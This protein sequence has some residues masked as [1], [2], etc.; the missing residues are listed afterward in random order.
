MRSFK[1]FLIIIILTLSLASCDI[2]A[3]GSEE[4]ISTEQ[5][6]ST[7]D[8]Y[9][10]YSIN[11]DNDKFSFNGDRDALMHENDTLTII[12]GGTYELSG[13]LKQ[14]KI[15]ID[16]GD[17]CVNL[18]LSENFS[19]GDRADAAIS[20]KSSGGTTLEIKGNSYNIYFTRSN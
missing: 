9:R 3:Q 14:G 7:A 12:K 13:N 11:F 10:P 8:S 2:L 16:T 20:V 15:V 19:L 17:A 4:S 5:S 18:V 6:V 1:I